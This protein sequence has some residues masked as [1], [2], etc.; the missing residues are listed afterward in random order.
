MILGLGES[1]RDLGKIK[2]WRK[3]NP[4]KPDSGVSGV[5]LKQNGIPV[6]I[7]TPY[8]SFCFHIFYSF[9]T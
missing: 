4:T 2:S 3:D 8:P 6:V 9:T 7:S 5:T 1:S